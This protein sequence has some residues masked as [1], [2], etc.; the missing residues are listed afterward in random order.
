MPTPS[1]TASPG[2]DPILERKVRWSRAA[3]LLERMWPRVWALA[4]LVGVFILL[5]LAGVWTELPELVH[6][7]CLVAFG[8]GALG[9]AAWLVRTPSATRDE[10]IRRIERQSGV[11]HRPASSYE[12]HLT[13]SAEQATNGHALGGP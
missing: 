6:K 3:L 12:D 10:A 13:A 11:P 9:L 2:L 1:S 5:S 8:A 7:L 4:A